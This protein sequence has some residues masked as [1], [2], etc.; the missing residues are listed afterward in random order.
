VAKQIIRVGNQLHNANCRR[1][2]CQF[3]YELEDVYRS[4]TLG[5]EWVTCPACGHAIRHFV[6]VAAHASALA[7]AR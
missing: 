3:T 6:A 4:Y 5:G 2:A 7:S 1:C